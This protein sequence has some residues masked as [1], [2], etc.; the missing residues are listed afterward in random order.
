MTKEWNQDACQRAV[1]KMDLIG[2]LPHSFVDNKGLRYF[3]TIAYWASFNFKVSWFG[4]SLKSGSSS[5]RTT[6]TIYGN[7][8]SSRRSSRSMYIRK[9]KGKVIETFNKLIWSVKFAML[10]I[11]PWTFAQN[12]SY[13][14][15]YL[16]LLIGAGAWIW[17]LLGLM[18]LKIIKEKR[19]AR[20]MRHVY[21]TKE[22]KGCLQ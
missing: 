14:W 18:W 4:T 11:D 7:Q 8:N 19:S 3:Y 1:T 20:R 21:R 2:E 12:M 6:I 16:I 10:T 13:M 22:Y 15:L 5:W 9:R 17:G